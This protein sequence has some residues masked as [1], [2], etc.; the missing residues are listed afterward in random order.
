LQ[1]QSATALGMPDWEL[2]RIDVRGS[3]VQDLTHP[4]TTASHE[5]Q[6]QTVSYFGGAEDD[7]ISLKEHDIF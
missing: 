4:H 2:L 1:R 3:Q 6:Y 5:C 7:L